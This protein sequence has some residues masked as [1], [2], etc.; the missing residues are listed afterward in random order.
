MSGAEA[1]A[2]AAVIV[3]LLAGP[4]GRAIARRIGGA[5][6]AALS[7]SDS[8]RIAEVE[9]RLQDLEAVQARMA[10]L[11]ERVDFTERRLAQRGETEKAIPSRSVHG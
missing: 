1:F 2:A 9:L 4:I 5:S 11:E 6:S 8:A 3:A 10:E 7:E